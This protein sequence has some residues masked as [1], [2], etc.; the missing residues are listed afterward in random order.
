[1]KNQIDINDHKYVQ[2]RYGKVVASMPSPLDRF[3]QINPHVSCFV[4]AGKTDI[5]SVFHVKPIYYEHRSSSETEL[6]FRPLYEV[7]EYYG[8][9]RITIKYE[10]LDEIQPS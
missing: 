10:K 1:M 4:I 9:H 6:I 5:V 2:E 8:N 3:G 7:C